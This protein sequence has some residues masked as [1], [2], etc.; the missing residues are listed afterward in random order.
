[1]I[2]LAYQ[3]LGAGLEDDAAGLR[4]LADNVAEVI[5]AASCS[6]NM[7]LYRERTGIILFQSKSASSARAIASQAKVAARKV[8]SMPPAHGG[9]LAGLVLTD[10]KLREDWIAELN[11][12]CMRINS[13]R[14]QV[15]TLLTGACG[16][17]FDFIRRE[18]GMFSFLGLTPEQ[19]KSLRSEHS[20]YMLDSSRINVAGINANNID[21]LVK[22]I[23]RV[24]S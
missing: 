21:Y 2:D 19:A 11:A 12:M 20:V 17:D 23:A 22:S 9:I 5:V 10:S 7:G 6:K 16:R 15:A 13:L 1:M 24:T 4:Y 8:Y 14:D 3:G 18:N